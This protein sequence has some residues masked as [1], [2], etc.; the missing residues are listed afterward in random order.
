[1][2]VIGKDLLDRP[3]VAVV[4][5]DRLERAQLVSALNVLLD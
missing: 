2:K 1:M 3:K 4:S 5:Y